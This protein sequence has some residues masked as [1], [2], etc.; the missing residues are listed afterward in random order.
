MDA[1]NEGLQTRTPVVRLPLWLAISGIILFIGSALLA[2]RII[3]EQTV[4]TWQRGPQMVGFSLAHGYGGILFIFPFLLILWTAA[5]AVLTVRSLIKKNEI[6]TRRWIGLGLGVALFVLM[7]MPEGFWQRVFVSQMAASPR[8]GDLLVYAAYRGDLGTVKA[9]I[10]HG[11]P[12]DAADHGDWRT[13]VHAAAV[14]NDVQA[15]GYLISAGANVNALDRAGDSPLEIAFSRGQEKSAQFLTEHGA[16]RVR[17]D[18]A[19]HQK[20]IN[21]KVREDIDVLDR[22]EASDKKLQEDIRKAESD[23]ENQRKKQQ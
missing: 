5:V 19:Q 1:L 4:W 18:D 7:T 23:E 13:A 2:A 16:K 12:I 8:A 21:D 20:A 11:V 3:W 17:G 9:L 6:A 10:S 14:G 15:L 22:A